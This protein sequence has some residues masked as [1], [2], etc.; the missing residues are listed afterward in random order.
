MA[1]LSVT[2]RNIDLVPLQPYM[3]QA[4][5][6]VLTGGAASAK[7]TLEFATGTARRVGFKGDLVLDGVA[8]LDSRARLSRDDDAIGTSK[9]GPLPGMTTQRDVVSSPK[10]P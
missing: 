9:V 3:T 4:A 10:F 5:R 6:V 2:A 8:V 7:G 1:T